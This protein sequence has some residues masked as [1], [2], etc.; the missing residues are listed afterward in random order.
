MTQDEFITK[1]LGKP[2]VNRSSTFDSVDCFGLIMLYYNHVLKINLPTVDGFIEKGDFV[3]CYDKGK[4]LWQEIDSPTENGIAF[5][6][7]RGETPIHVGLCIGHGYALH[8]RGSEKQHGK[9]EIHSL[10]AIERLYGRI[11]YHKFTG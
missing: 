9:V 10:R 1:I 4:T 3:T 7:Y 5:T 8:C 2:W 6:C 11:S